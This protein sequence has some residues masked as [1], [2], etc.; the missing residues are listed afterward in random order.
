[1]YVNNLRSSVYNMLDLT[2]Q[3]RDDWCAKLAADGPHWSP[4]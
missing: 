2:P 1:M 3:G 4:R